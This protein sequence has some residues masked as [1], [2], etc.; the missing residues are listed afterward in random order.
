MDERTSARIWR[1]PGLLAL[2]LVPFALLIDDGGVALALPR[3][4]SDASLA[5]FSIPWT[6][7]AYALGV[8]GIVVFG[9]PAG[10]RW[11]RRRIL[12]LGL[13]FFVAG[14]AAGAVAGN[15]IVLALARALQGVGAG[16]AT[17]TS[18]ALVA[19]STVAERRG[20]SLGLWAGAGSS[21]IALGP[22]L[23]SAAVDLLGWRAV[24]GL[25]LVFGV[26]A[27]AA[28]VRC[29]SRDPVR[30]ERPVDVL[31]V[32][33]I[34][35]GLMAG[36][37]VLTRVGF[38]PVNVALS[39][40][41]ALATLLFVRRC[42]GPGSLVNLGRLRSQPGVLRAHAIA[43]L[44][45]AVMCNFLFFFAIEL[46][47]AQGLSPLLA[48][49]AL[50]PFAAGLTLTAPLVG[51]A[52]DRRGTAIVLLVSGGV[53][54]VSQIALATVGAHASVAAVVA[55]SL[56]AGAALGATATAATAGAMHLVPDDKLGESAGTLAAA[57][58]LGL[59]LGVSLMARIAG[60]AWP[61]GLAGSDGERIQ[62]G[63]SAG[64]SVNAV[65]G[66]ATVAIALFGMRGQRRTRIVRRITRETN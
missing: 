33:F 53:V 15:G 13:A 28:V 51:R 39:V 57:R 63:I 52:V 66:A 32:A 54:F 16:L 44:V 22:V 47:L 48:G 5:A 43:L 36:V 40:T 2:A 38:D 41:A 10:D 8:A 14:A 62:S 7:A 21:A 6:V 17:P 12:L 42:S 34:G 61:D 49:A 59:A 55:L 24:F 4:A 30:A 37:V 1:S 27:L 56:V 31:A 11:G 46:Q 3:I 58:V 20:E 23:G 60:Y 9:G 29:V 18:L 65:I 45:N 26:A 25:D 64:L 35:T 50:I 19:A